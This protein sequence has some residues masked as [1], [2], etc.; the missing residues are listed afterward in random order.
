MN[1]QIEKQ[2]EEPA[3]KK[4]KT[5]DSVSEASTRANSDVSPRP[6]VRSLSS[7]EKREQEQRRQTM[8]AQERVKLARARIE[9]TRSEQRERTEQR[10][11]EEKRV[12]E[13][14]RIRM[15]EAEARSKK[16]E[17]DRQ[18]RIQEEKLRKSLEARK[19]KI[20]ALQ[21]ERENIERNFFH[22]NQ[23]QKSFEKIKHSGR[24]LKNFDAKSRFSN[25]SFTTFD[26]FQFS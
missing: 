23:E 22:L 20:A 12:R 13:E 6:L 11:R 15:Q 1:N 2:P 24:N 26:V 21:R 10:E 16:V 9:K 25:F 4:L 7:E 8:A 18:A 19:A 3:M 5:R 17:A 14:Q